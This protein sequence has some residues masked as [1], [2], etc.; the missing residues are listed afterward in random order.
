MDPIKEAF[1]KIKKDMKLLTDSLLDVKSGLDS[2]TKDVNTLK[3]DK[4]NNQSKRDSLDT[5]LLSLNTKKIPFRIPSFY[6][7]ESSPSL[8]RHITYTPKN[9][10]FSQSKRHHRLSYFLNY[11]E[12]DTNP[13]QDTQKRTNISP[14]Y[15]NM[16]LSTG[17]ARSF[18]KPTDNS[19]RQTDRQ[20]DN[21]RSEA[22]KTQN[23]IFSKG[24]SGVPTDRQ[25][26]NQTVR[27]TDSTPIKDDFSGLNGFDKA[28]DVISSL[29]G[30]KSEIKSIFK[31]LTGQEIL[32]LS[33]IY[34]LEEEN[35]PEIDYN[36]LSKK[37]G[38]TQS[39]I[40]DYV[41]KLTKKGIPISKTKINNKK[42]VLSLSDK[43]K[44]I[45]P[46]STILDLQNS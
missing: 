38:L 36:I 42:I 20:T 31:S 40:R 12:N 22:L 18:D 25:T 7:S 8:S 10:F 15:Q 41:N 11:Y 14:T 33:T 29:D 46:L 34:T 37:L 21:F 19:D 17:F 24:N 43:L 39:S 9:L 27:Q 26:N 4:I 16:T 3:E 32:I 13:S 23:P 30:L 2:L 28:N 6:S 44:K 1:L 5:K 45:A 35:T